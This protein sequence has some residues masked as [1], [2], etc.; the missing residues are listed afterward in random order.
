MISQYKRDGAFLPQ[1]L[2]N[3][4][5][6]IIAK[7]NIDQNSKSTTATRHYYGTSLF[8]F[9][10][11]TEEKPGI[12]VEYGDLKSS[13]NRSSLKINALQSF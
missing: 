4:I 8:I 1:T 13:S 10:F 7:D 2:K 6:T 12:V 5:L 9:Q 3:G 11:P